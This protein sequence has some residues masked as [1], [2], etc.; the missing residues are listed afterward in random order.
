MV[1]KKEE[2]IW[3]ERDLRAASSRIQNQMQQAKKVGAN[4]QKVHSKLLDSLHFL[5][6]NNEPSARDN[7]I[8]AKIELTEAVRGLKV[9]SHISYLFR[10]YGLHSILYAIVLMLVFF[11]GLW[12]Y[13]DQEF[14]STPYVTVPIWSLLIAGVGSTVQILMGVCNDIRETGTIRIY[15]RSWFWSL[16]FISLGLG[17]AMY[18]IIQCGLLAVNSDGIDTSSEYLP[19]LLCFI[20]GYSTDWVRVKL[21]QAMESL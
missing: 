5:D 14:I 9:P 1:E 12:Y 17:F 18:L 6:N 13:K 8:E 19:M 10:I 3:T 20:A 15:K 7:L 11:L 4:I 21:S 2:K 16:P